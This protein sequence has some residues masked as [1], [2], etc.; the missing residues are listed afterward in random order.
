MFERNKL[1]ALL[2]LEKAKKEGLADESILPLVDMI[3]SLENFYTASSCG[4]RAV[5]A[6]SDKLDRKSNFNF[7]GKWHSKVSFD[8]IASAIKKYKKNMLWFRAEPVILHLGCASFKDAEI[9]LRAA[10]QAG[11]KRSGIFS[12]N[13]RIM[14]EIRGVDEF[15]API[16]KNGKVIV[17]NDYIRYLTEIANLKL[18]KNRRKIEIFEK[19]LKKLQ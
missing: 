16:G 10:H 9:M 5:I 8:A 3:N 2:K 14:L 11:L 7:L 18:D 19:N 12:V 6:E 4:G 1:A 17:S 15:S 13:R